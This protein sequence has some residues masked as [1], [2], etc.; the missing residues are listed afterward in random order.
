[1]KILVTGGAGYIGT[2]TCVALLEA[3]HEVVVVDNLSRGSAEGLRL[4]TAIAGGKIT[5]YPVDIRD[6]D[7]MDMI[8]SLNDFDAVIHFAGLKSVWESVTD[9]M[10]YYEENVVGTLA[11]LRVMDAHGVRR[12]V[13]SSS[14]AVYGNGYTPPYHEGHPLRPMTP[15]AETKMVIERMLTNLYD[16]G[17][18]WAVMALRY[19]NPVGAHSSGLI[20]EDPAYASGNLMPQILRVALG[21]KERLEVYGDCYDTFDGSG[22]RDFIHVMDL[23]EGHVAALDRMVEH[24]GCHTYNLGLGRGHTVIN[25]IKTFESVT[26][27]PVPYTVVGPRDG[28]IGISYASVVKARRDLNWAPKRSMSDMCADALRWATLHPEGYVGTPSIGVVAHFEDGQHI[29]LYNAYV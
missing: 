21:Q 6:M 19:F 13:F 8:F 2:H 1:M 18:G 10:M 4:A 26:G 7:R 23:A 11:L 24:G 27:V 12:I 20:G 14:A 29:P 22:L 9:P 5:L 17:K 15:Y 16:T 25:M 3:G 28:D